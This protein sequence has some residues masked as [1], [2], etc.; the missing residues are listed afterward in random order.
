M[1]A[2]GTSS[3]VKTEMHPSPD[4]LSEAQR[5]DSLTDYGLLDTPPEEA[6][7]SL[8]LLA[9]HICDAPIA[10]LTLIDKD[11]Q[12]FKSKY[13]FTVEQTSRDVSFCAHAILQPND[14]LVVADTLNDERF[15]Q[16]PF[17]IGAPYVRFYAGAP[18]VSPEGQALG[19]LC[20]IDHSPRV[21]SENHQMAL[22]VLS[23][24]VMTELELRR[25]SR[26]L[27]TTKQRLAEQE[28]AA[29][30]LRT[31]EALFQTLARAAPV[32]IF[33][34]DASGDCIY[35]NEQWTKITG[36][37]S[38]AARGNDW[39]QNLHPHDKQ[40][41]AERW[42][43]AVAEGKAF[44]AEYRFVKPN[45]DITWVLGQGL[46]EENST[47]GKNGYVG[48]ITDITERKL[49]EE[50]LHQS[51][52]L[53]RGVMESSEDC[54]KF[55]DLDGR[56][57][58]INERGRRLM[59]IDDSAPMQ[60]RAWQDF[61]PPEERVTVNSALV[62][63]RAGKPGRFTAHASTAKGKS[64]WWD[65]IVTPI[66]D[67]TGA[68]EKFL[69]V[70]RDVTEQKRTEQ[71]LAWEKTA[72]DLIGA[73][74]SLNYILDQLMIG[75]ESRLPGALCSVVLLK[76]DGK[77]LEHGGAPSLPPS[78]CRAIEQA[79]IGPR[80]G[81][82]GTAMYLN[83]QVIVADIECDP[84]WADYRE[85]ARAHGLR[86]CWSTPVRTSAGKVVGS[87]AI[88]YRVPRV[89]TP[90]EEELIERANHIVSLAIERKRAAEALHLS[91]ERLQLV[92]RATN[93]AVWDWDLVTNSIW[94]NA[95]FKSLF[96]HVAA[97]IEPRAETWE[98]RVH[99][100]DLTRVKKGIHHV[101]ESRGVS[102]SDEYR[103]C[104]RDGSY[105]DILDR[106]YII[107]GPDGQAVRMIG[108]MIDISEQKR[109]EQALRMSEERFRQLAENITEVF[110]V[111][112]I[113][114]QRVIYVSPAYARVWGRTCESLYSSSQSWEDSIYPED[115]ARVKEAVRDKQLRGDYDETYRIQRPDG[116]VRWIRDR[117][118]PVRTSSGEFYRIV[119]IAEDI[120]ERKI[121][122]A[123][124]LQSQRMETVGQLAG[125]VAHDIN[126]I[127]AP[128]MMSV[129]LLRMGMEPAE[130][131]RTLNMIEASAQRGSEV[132]KQ[133]LLFGRGLEGNRSCVQF[134]KLIEEIAK[135]VRKSFLKNIIL[136][137]DV[138]PDAWPV[139]G[140]PTQLHQVLLN[141]CVNAR[142]A[143]PEGGSLS[144]KVKN[145]TL[146][147]NDAV[148]DT[149]ARPGLYV[150]LSVSDSGMGM[151]KEVLSRIFDPF[152]TTKAIGQGTGLGLS[153]VLGIV[154]SHRGFIKV[155]SQVGQGSIFD[156]Y[157]PA[158]PG[159]VQFDADP[160]P[161]ELPL[162]E[163]Q[164][165]L[166]VDDEAY[167]R[168]TVSQTLLRN[169]YRVELAENGTE[170]LVVY[171]RHRDE[172]KVVV[173]DLDMPSMD[174]AR[175]LQVLRA[176][177]PQLK[178]IVSSGISG[179]SMSKTRIGELAAL[180]IT[181][182]LA[183][184]YTAEKILSVLHS[185]L[186]A[187]VS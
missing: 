169:G 86:A 113:L 58:F 93:D 82:C 116:R 158:S 166:V 47:T 96:G 45:G 164:M 89:I 157:F 10:L 126:N 137:V 138:P 103:F 51:E 104:R 172:I 54:I 122:E 117:A 100:E 50:K 69:C 48:T 63:A 72:L 123:Q 95:G 105:A 16:N 61:W 91:G 81:S 74:F 143:M 187:E 94:W 77:H 142:D 112:D 25:R 17:V 151:S 65:V 19:T 75:L 76:S 155:R 49:A 4:P 70:S 30:A 179:N 182:F 60:G 186:H 141:L 170:A 21:L 26:A 33:R 185:L 119:G 5:L 92:A 176:E 64:R 32:G 8:T 39:S 128:I 101:I 147:A 118:Y 34:S 106:G 173:S 148:I 111:T 23:R 120:T 121:M 180:G 99:P 139:L 161:V 114:K 1:T 108:A 52:E 35:V 46:P 181:T 135:I 149:E 160:L 42:Y 85:L 66:P 53:L 130:V 109:T 131:D 153:T 162:G 156:I 11:R 102:W 184:P 37:S 28:Q 2:A 115:R 18:L 165:I 163:N 174:G 20:V 31:S 110:W 67:V 144:L 13:N 9:A 29:A 83:R 78:F 14:V 154:K 43:C 88:Y 133:L 41:V 22:R 150:L 127:L 175:L 24:H 57:L 97:E 44:N 6:F 27:T 12:W 177:N 36:L 107:H 145:L 7:D 183:K 168:E 171:S 178:I 56:I 71:L 125:G 140:D 79:T 134:S 129:S 87:F 73:S 124:L 146:D 132:V 3:R 15:A 90:I 68:P 159:S 167:I 38:E 40:R 136:T 59:E 62:Q 55:L 98:T 84:L 80:A 152:F